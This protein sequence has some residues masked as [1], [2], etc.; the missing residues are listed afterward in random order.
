MRLQIQ[1]VS[2]FQHDMLKRRRRNGCDQINNSYALDDNR[3]LNTTAAVMDRY[4]IAPEALVSVPKYMRN[5]SIAKYDELTAHS[6]PY[7]DFHNTA[8]SQWWCS[9]LSRGLLP[10]IPRILR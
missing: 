9:C 10:I 4:P 8:T 7:R 5:P 1:S 2:S 6:K 3:N